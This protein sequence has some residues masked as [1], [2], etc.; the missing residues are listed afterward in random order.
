MGGP[1]LLAA[2]YGGDRPPRDPNAKRHYTEDE[3]ELRSRFHE[4]DNGWISLRFDEFLGGDTALRLGLFAVGI[5]GMV[6]LRHR[7]DGLVLAAFVVVPM[8]VLFVPPVCSALRD[9]VGARWPLLRI[10]PVAGTAVAVGVFGVLGLAVDRFLPGTW[11]R[12]LR[13]APLT[14]IIVAL[15]MSTIWSRAEYSWKEYLVDVAK[16]ARKRLLWLNFL[17]RERAFYARNIEPGSVVLA[18]PRDGRAL[19]ML[20]DCYI[21]MVDRSG[22]VGM[23]LPERKRDLAD[24]LWPATP[25]P[26]RKALLQKYGIDRVLKTDRSEYLLDWVEGHERGEIRD[27]RLDQSLVVLDMDS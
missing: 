1:F 27:R 15:A 8:V 4:W 19:V 23:Q 16:P 12:L 6:L 10:G 13:R 22:G 3:E 24:L 11:P 2:R 25:W 5:V 17:R 7:R 21:V 14:L 20:C 18:H 9:L 26:R